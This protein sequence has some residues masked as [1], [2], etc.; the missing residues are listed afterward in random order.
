MIMRLWGSEET[1]ELTYDDADLISPYALE[2]MQQAQAAGL[3]TGYEDNTLQP[4]RGLRRSEA[5]A[6]AVRLLSWQA[7]E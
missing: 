1:A 5:V 3:I 6:L 7:A 4:Q 2:A